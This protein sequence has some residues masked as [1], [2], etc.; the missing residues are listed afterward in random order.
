LATKH[1]HYFVARLLA[2]SG[3]SGRIVGYV[4][5]WSILDESHLTSIAVDPV[6]QGRGV[7]KALLRFAIAEA[8]SRGAAMMTL[9]VRVSN[10]TAIALYR[11]HGFEIERRRKNYYSDIKEDAFVMN[12]FR[13]SEPAYLR[14]ILDEGG[15][16]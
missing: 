12:C 1:A 2:E 14:S 7:G 6:H 15:Q 8:V 9:E 3:E 10:A 5:I 11:A 4:G 16:R 13:V